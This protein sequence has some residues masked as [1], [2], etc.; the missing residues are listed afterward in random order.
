MKFRQYAVVTD[1]QNSLLL[2]F[3]VVES[4]CKNILD[5]RFHSSYHPPTK[6]HEGNVFTPVCHSVHREGC[7][8]ACF[9]QGMCI[10]SSGSSGQVRGGEKHE[11]YAA[12]SGS[13]LF[14]DLFL[15]GWGGHTPL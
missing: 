9:G 6:L 4:E 1:L 12:A 8:Q 11:I 2:W 14:Y 15:Q 7:I 3:N 10:P 13:H 5:H